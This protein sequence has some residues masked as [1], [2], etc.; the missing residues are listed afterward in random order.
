ML[1]YERG[2]SAGGSERGLVNIPRSVFAKQ[3]GIVSGER[4]VVLMGIKMTNW[5]TRA[6]PAYRN[7]AD[8]YL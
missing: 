7:C 3:S 4:E 5:T 8:K 2:A 6:N 1:S